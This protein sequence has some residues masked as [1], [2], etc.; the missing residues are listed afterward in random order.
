MGRIRK[1]NVTRPLPTEFLL[2]NTFLQINSTPS[3]YFFQYR[4]ELILQQLIFWLFRKTGIYFFL[5]QLK[6]R[7]YL[8]LLHFFVYKTYLNRQLK[9]RTRR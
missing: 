9:K 8:F 7:D 3:T 6:Q 1:K 4:Q 2:P 5:A